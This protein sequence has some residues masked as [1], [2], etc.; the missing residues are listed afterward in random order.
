MGTKIFAG[1]ISD[2]QKYKMRFLQLAAKMWG[3]ATTLHDQEFL[4]QLLLGMVAK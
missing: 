4:G 2:A 1:L 3:Q